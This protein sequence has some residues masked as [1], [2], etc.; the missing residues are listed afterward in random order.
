MNLRPL[1]KEKMLSMMR[2]FNIDNQFLKEH[3]RSED[4]L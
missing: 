2:R 3:I 1:F 4:I